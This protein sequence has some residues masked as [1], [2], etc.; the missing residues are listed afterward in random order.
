[1][2]RLSLCTGF[3]KP[4]L[5]SSMTRHFPEE[6]V[7][8]D[9]CKVFDEGWHYG[10]VVGANDRGYFVCFEQD[11]F[12]AAVFASTLPRGVALHARHVKFADVKIRRDDAS[13]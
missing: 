10:Q 6:V 13:P 5:I 8:G 11:F 12:S 7:V 1:M 9:T 3:D 2:L 4:I